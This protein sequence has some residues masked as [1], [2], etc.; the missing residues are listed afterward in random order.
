MPGIPGV[1]SSLSRGAPGGL[2]RPPGGSSG[3]P[4]GGAGSPPGGGALLRSSPSFVQAAKQLPK[5]GPAPFNPAIKPTVPAAT[6]PAAAVPAAAKATAASVSPLAI[7]AVAI[8]GFATGFII[9]NEARKVAIQAL[10]ERGEFLRYPGEVLPADI[11]SKFHEP[12]VTTTEDPSYLGGQCDALYRVTGQGTNPDGSDRGITQLAF[13]P[14]PLG[15]MFTTQGQNIHSVNI[16]LQTATGPQYF[17]GNAPKGT[18]VTILS[19]ERLDGA[20]DNCGNPAG[21]PLPAPYPLAPALESQP[22]LQSQPRSAPTSAGAPAPAP[23]PSLALAPNL[24]PQPQPQPGLELLPEVSPLPALAPAID[25]ITEQPALAPGLR[26]PGSAL[27]PQLLAPSQGQTSDA[28]RKQLPPSLTF[29]PNPTEI[30]EI[31]DP[32]DPGRFTKTAVADPPKPSSPSANS[33]ECELPMR[34]LGNDL[35]EQLDNL[36]HQNCCNHILARLQVLEQL[37][38]PAIAGSVDLSDCDDSASVTQSYGGEGLQGL[39]A[40]VE[41]LIALAS[42][43]W[44]ATRCQPQ[45]IQAI[46]TSCETQSQSH[47]QSHELL[48]QIAQRLSIADFPATVPASLLGS[49]PATTQIESLGELLAWLIQQFDALLGEWPIQVQLD[50]DASQGIQAAEIELANLAEAIAE[51]YGLTLNA[52]IDADNNTNM[53]VRALSE[54]VGLKNMSQITQDIAFA[55]SEYLGYRLQR[56]QREMAASVTP[57]QA[58]QFNQFL[59]N[60]TYEILSYENID[61]HTVQDYLMKLMFAAGIIKANFFKGAAQDGAGNAAANLVRDLLKP[62]GNAG[63]QFWHEFLDI[64]TAPNYIGNNGIRARIRELFTDVGEPETPTSEDT[65]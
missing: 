12:T 3:L 24:A 6:V 40:Q 65:P 48:A 49:G 17:Y 56:T 9:G 23:R 31:L 13:A 26:P 29:L 42:K 60:S 21:Q 51:I 28:A 58:A 63:E 59:Q 53:L 44:A 22:Q 62:E 43:Q 4:P 46:N 1:G 64:V 36:A 41:A 35:R 20:P 25:P 30:A 15:E 19:V 38:T 8:G 55:N 37:L 16:G 52:G 2:G 33:C 14:G 39:S 54:L 47:E 50:A 5:P 61:Q 34:R 57:T 10:G 7:A 45:I 11:A 32:I 27:Q 18:T